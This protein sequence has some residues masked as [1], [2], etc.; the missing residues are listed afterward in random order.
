MQTLNHDSKIIVGVSDLESSDKK[1]ALSV[2][3]VDDDPS[4]LE[5]SKQILMDMDN[6]K[7]DHASS[8]DEAF[9]KLANES[10]DVVVSD[11]EMPTKNGL[12]FLKELREQ[13]NDIP[14]IM[15][16]GKAEKK[17]LLMP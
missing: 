14:F 2:L 6:F 1:S 4:I 17:L 15:F 7:I 5:I 8:V 10:Y 12:E 16:T 9:S 3:H 11:Y 13:K